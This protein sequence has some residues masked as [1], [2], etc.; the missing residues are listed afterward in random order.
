[1]LRLGGFGALSAGPPAMTKAVISR[2][3][4]N[5]FIHVIPITDSSNNMEWFTDSPTPEFHLEDPELCGNALSSSGPFLKAPHRNF[6]G[7]TFGGI[8]ISFESI[9]CD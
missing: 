2:K 5:I 6:C 4:P 7:Q 3:V 9:C 1:M 8:N